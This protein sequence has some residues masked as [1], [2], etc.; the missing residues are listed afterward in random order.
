MVTAQHVV[1]QARKLHEPY[2]QAQVGIGFAIPNSDDFR[3]NFVITGFNVVEEDEGHDLALLKLKKNP[4]LGELRSGIVIGSEE[5]P[6]LF[7]VPRLRPDRP[8]DGEPIAISGYPR[9]APDECSATAHRMNGVAP[10]TSWLGSKMAT[11]PG[12]GPGLGGAPG[13]VLRGTRS[14]FT[15]FSSWPSML[16]WKE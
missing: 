15:R 7:G 3:A 4:F 2:P 6:L 5:I 1:R 16:A 14:K 13:I 12:G 11:Y 8:R 9:P 10:V